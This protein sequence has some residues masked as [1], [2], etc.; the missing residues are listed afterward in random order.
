MSDY[1]PHRDGDLAQW[2]ENFNTKLP[3]HATAVGVLP[4]EVTEVDTVITAHNASYVEMVAVK[5]TA[6]S[7]VAAN[8][9]RKKSMRDLVRP[10]VQRIKNHPGY[11]DEIG[12]DLGIVGPSSTID[13]MNA[14]PTIKAASGASGVTIDFNKS[15]FDG[16]KIYSR[17]GSET[18]FTFLANDTN[19]PYHDTRVNLNS[20]DAELREYYAV[21][22]LNDDPI[23]KESD[24][25]KITVMKM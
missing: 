1:M 23:G 7:K 6:K 24:I 25:V 5:D 16:I 11:T 17:R 8:T 21:Y 22:I 15:E 2:E 14:K 4:A 18:E 3:G 19:P 13:I 9:A 12:K 10:L 20:A